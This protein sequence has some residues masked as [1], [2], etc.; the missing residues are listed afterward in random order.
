[1][2][3]KQ[4]KHVSFD[5][6]MTLIRSNPGFKQKRAGLFRDYFEIQRSLEDVQLSVRKFDVLV[7]EINESIG[8]NV[9]TFELYIL[10]LNDLGVDHKKYTL[11]D[12]NAFYAHTEHLFREYRPEPII[13]KL[14]FRLE[15]LHAASITMNILSN[16]GFIRGHTLRELLDHYG[17]GQYFTFQIYS[18]EACISKP[19]PLIFDKVYE[20]ISKTTIFDKKQIL[21]VGDNPR[22]DFNGA[23]TYGFSAY[24]LENQ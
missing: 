8:R 5:L 9:D 23:R 20:E 6:W 13:D 14:P 11:A 4:Y 15:D 18:D 16:T 3:Y 24:L 21:H 7:N 17:L 22:A 10:I 1:M 19:N 2:D 12:F